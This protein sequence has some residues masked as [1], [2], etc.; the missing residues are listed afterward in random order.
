MSDIKLHNSYN[1]HWQTGNGDNWSVVGTC[2]SVTVK[3][4]KGLQETYTAKK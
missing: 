3:F 4:N 1:Y 2:M